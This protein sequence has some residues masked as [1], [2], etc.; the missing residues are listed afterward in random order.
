[1]HCNGC[2]LTFSPPSKL[3]AIPVQVWKPCRILKD[4]DLGAF[5]PESDVGETHLVLA[6]E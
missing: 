5:L 2:G 3:A 1:V 4:R 6:L